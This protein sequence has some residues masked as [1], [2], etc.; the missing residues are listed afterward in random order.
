MNVMDYLVRLHL[1]KI[2]LQLAIG[3]SIKKIADTTGGTYFNAAGADGMKEVMARINELEKT[4][5]E[6]PRYIEYREYAP[7]IALAALAMM[8]F[9]LVAETTFKLRLP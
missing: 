6:Q 3:L 2:Q 9:G 4:T 1:R 5:L 7:A 8:L